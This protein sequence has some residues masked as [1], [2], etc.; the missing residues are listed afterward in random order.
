MEEKLRKIEIENITI[1]IYFILL[2]LYLYGNKIEVNYVKY[3]NEE[4]KDIYRFILYIVFGGI[5]I[6]SLYYTISGFSSFS[7]YD[8]EKVTKLKEL[9]LISNILILLAS[10]ILLYIV[11]SDKEINIEVNPS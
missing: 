4:D 5:F 6:L 9:S 3:G 2:L 10:I 11:Y 7:L 1:Y 8:D